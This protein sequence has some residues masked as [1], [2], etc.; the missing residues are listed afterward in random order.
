MELEILGIRHHGPGSSRH[1]L[2]ALTAFQP[3]A[4][5]IEGPPEANSLLRFI[6]EINLSPPVALIVYEESNPQKAVFFPFTEYSP[7]Y[8]AVLY[9]NKNK[10]VCRFA[11]LPQAHQ[12]TFKEEENDISLK[13]DP[14]RLLTAAAGFT[15]TERWWEHFVEKKTNSEDLF[16]SLLEMMHEI[17]DFEPETDHV[18]LLREAFMR[19]SIFA[20]QKEGFKRVAFVCGAWHSPSLTTW[21]SDAKTDVQLL[22]KLPKLKTLA[23]WIPWT[24]QKMA[25]QAGYR[26]GINSP[27]WY[28]FIWRNAGRSTEIWMIEAANLLRKYGFDTSSSSVIEAVRLA[29]TLSYMREM[30]FA[31]LEELK[32]AAR[33]VLCN[34]DEE[35]LLLIEK[36]LIIGEKIG[37]ISEEIP[38]IPLQQ[39]FYKAAKTLKIPLKATDTVVQLDLRTDYHLLKSVFLHRLNLLGVPFAYYKQS[40]NKLGT[41]HEQWLVRW[42]S[43]GE[44]ALI[45]ANVWGNT[46]YSAAIARTMHDLKDLKSIAPITEMLS[47][48]LLADLKELV[49]YAL[50][51]LNQAT[52]MHNDV[53][54]LMAAVPPLVRIL[55]YGD[56]RG[57]DSSALSLSLREITERILVALPMSFYQISDEQ[58]A[59]YYLILEE[60]Y[61][62]L[63]T[64]G[65]FLSEL[66]DVLK[67][68]AF[69]EST[70]PYLA[71]LSTRIIFDNA[72]LTK[73]DMLIL[74]SY[75]LSLTEQLQTNAQWL[76]GFIGSNAQ[77]L[78][79]DDALWHLIND[80]VQDLH[81]EDFHRLL[82][83]FRR[84]FSK[85][86]SNEKAHL[87]EK[88]QEKDILEIKKIV[89]SP[90]QE[91]L[92][93]KAKVQLEKLIS[94]V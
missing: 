75:R 60:F 50:S 38:L 71:G 90:S 41:F 47:K 31:G 36:E 67:K 82:P 25:L 64:L 73:N 10:V 79:Y 58:A 94:K 2:K 6:D 87:V 66:Y 62:A 84:V 27:M 11:D 59:H 26:A 28:E 32:D 29:E 16:A 56:V 85:L 80:W 89:L 69:N 68:I 4:I 13:K 88:L 65:D 23:T 51:T 45:D 3:D 43:S 53:G 35:P 74:V 22:K 48:I 81:Q 34:G 54:D 20:A 49:N 8:Q 46:V 24:Y 76:E 77:I 15:D 39:D 19:Q 63:L 14:F 93:E 9:A 40:Y 92:W 21:E 42:T 30:H 33:T 83:L 78:L 61:Q 72:V 52:A 17:R 18:T 44:I 91:L 37:Q 70:H 5:L 1:L 57:T 12:M 55:R 86:D 7:E